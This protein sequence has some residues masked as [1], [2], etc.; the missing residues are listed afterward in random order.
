[1]LLRTL[2]WRATG[3]LTLAAAFFACEGGP[4]T[5]FSSPPIESGLPPTL[6]EP[7]V[8]VAFSHDANPVR[9][10]DFADPF[11]LVTDSLYYAY[12]TNVGSS[13][14]P[15]LASRDLVSWRPAGDALPVL[16]EWAVSG[17]RKTWAPAVLASAGRYLLFYTARDRTSSRQCIGQAESLSPAGPFLDR[18]S[19]PFLC[20]LDL[21]GSIDASVVRDSS[22]A[23][24]LLWK[25]DGNCCGQPVMLWSQRLSVDGAALE[26]RP[27]AVLRPDQAW[28]GPLIEA[29]TM[30][31][32]DGSWHLLY[33]ANLWNTDRYAIGYAECDTPLGPC[34]KVGQG[35][36][37]GSDQETAG[38]GGAEV[39]QDHDGRRWVAY[40]G[41][42]APWIGYSQGGARSFRLDRIEL[43]ENPVAAR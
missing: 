32:Q 34:R 6:A 14:V 5:P 38:P 37:M 11:V 40:H 39:F 16:G 42:T 29:P 22:G 13:N 41:W 17:H 43:V 23:P 21:G 28:E 31:Y 15:V 26:G 12:A 19:T 18:H 35:P 4:S 8:P 33:S 10:G 30:W 24:F 1:M 2:L 36:V 27:V 3:A 9:P 7:D 20:Q 25:N